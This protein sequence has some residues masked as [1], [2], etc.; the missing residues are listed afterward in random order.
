M[1]K[2]SDEIREFVRR[3]YED[4]HMDPRELLAL[5]DRVDTE[6]VELPKDADGREVPLDTRELVHKGETSDVL[7]IAYSVPLGCWVAD[8][9]ETSEHPLISSCY[10]PDSWE[11]IADELVEWCNS[12]D[13]DGD[14]CD[15]P[16]VLAERIRKLA[17]KEG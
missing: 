17:E 11:R 10:L 1:T 7:R 12:V 3:S 6:M 5:A 4:E 13:V 15:V 8:L 14:S 2:I 16:R 9:A